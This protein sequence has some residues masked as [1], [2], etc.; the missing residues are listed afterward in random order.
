MKNIY[1][2][3]IEETMSPQEF[4][5]AL[6]DLC[7]AAKLLSDAE[8]ASRQFFVQDVGAYTAPDWKVGWKYG[9]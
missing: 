5:E 4:V 8:F 6:L 2:I 1:G 3:P 9:G 7:H